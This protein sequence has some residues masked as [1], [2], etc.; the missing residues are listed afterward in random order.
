MFNV[1]MRGATLLLLFLFSQVPAVPAQ[2]ISPTRFPL[3]KATGVNPDTHLTLTFSRPPTLGKSGQIRIYEASNDKLVDTL[4]LS[5]P[6]G[7]ITPAAGPAAPYTHVP[8]EY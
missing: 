7:P 5:I 3:D 4:D 1:T 8:Y 6:P 2:G